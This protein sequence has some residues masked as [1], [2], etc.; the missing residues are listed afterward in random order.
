MGPVTA[1]IR[2]RGLSPSLAIGNLIGT[3]KVVPFS[4]LDL[5][6]RDLAI[7]NCRY[8][9]FAT[10][11]STQV[12]EARAETLRLLL[13]WPLTSLWLVDLRLLGRA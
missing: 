8:G 5:A 12:A 11:G 2:I 9:T 10:L 4:N 6:H 13:C 1:Y 7:V 3:T